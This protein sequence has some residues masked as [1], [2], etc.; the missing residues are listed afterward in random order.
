MVLAYT[1]TSNSFYKGLCLSLN[2]VFQ[3][4]FCRHISSGDLEFCQVPEHRFAVEIFEFPSVLLFK[5]GF[6]K[7][8][9]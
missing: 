1:E 3:L 8:G 5:R 7:I 4:L 6:L 9:C 2:T